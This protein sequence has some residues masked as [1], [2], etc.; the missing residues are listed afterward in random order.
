[1]PGTSK[2]K[3]PRGVEVEFEEAS[4]IYST[5]K[6]GKETKKTVKQTLEGVGVLDDYAETWYIINKITTKENGNKTTSNSK[7]KDMDF[8]TRE[9]DIL[10]FPIACNDLLELILRVFE[11]YPTSNGNYFFIDG[12][13]CMLLKQSSS[14]LEKTAFM[15][16]GSKIDRV[17]IIKEDAYSELDYKILFRDRENISIPSD[18]DSYEDY[19]G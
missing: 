17:H 5:I 10:S 16:D 13:D 7:Y 8:H 12:D 15:Y 18:A 11:E 2:A 3:N 1:M 9:L 4:H 19:F 6:N 14:K